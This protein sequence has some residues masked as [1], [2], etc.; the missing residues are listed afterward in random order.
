MKSFTRPGASAWLALL[1]S[2]CT[3]PALESATRLEPYQCGNVQ[4]IHAF[5]DVLLASQ[6]GPDDFKKASVNTVVN[7]RHASEIDGDE[8]AI[9]QGLGMDY[10]NLPF[11][12]PAELTDA[13][14]DQAREL[15]SDPDNKPLLL[16][17]S[18]GNRVGAIWLAHRVLDHGLSLEEASIEAET[19]GL[20]TPALAD[21]AREYIEAQ[22]SASPAQPR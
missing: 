8:A 4:R 11:Q 2:A 18:S 19:V 16:H 7:L 20:K 6:P 14:F 12:S 17:C 21:R 15:L 1:L 5:G 13:V 3:S 10:H 9:V 22:R